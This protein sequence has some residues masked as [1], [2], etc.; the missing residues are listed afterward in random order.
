M[1]SDLLWTDRHTTWRKIDA[2]PRIPK[3][4]SPKGTSTV[5]PVYI[6]P[7][8]SCII[9]VQSSRLKCL[10]W[11]SESSHSI[12]LGLDETI[13]HIWQH[14]HSILGCISRHTC[15]ICKIILRIE[16]SLNPLHN[17]LRGVNITVSM[18]SHVLEWAKQPIR[19]ATGF[20]SHVCIH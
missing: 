2:L 15:S 8:G 9:L 1:G 14:V 6:A 5:H 12:I 20:S 19:L 18:T 7:A 4:T 11:S 17:T 16:W 3:R 10:P 13:G